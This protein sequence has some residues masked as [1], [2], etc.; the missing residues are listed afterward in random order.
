M[1]YASTIKNKA[2]RT[3]Y[4]TLVG[5]QRAITVT[6]CLAVP[7][8]V[9]YQV[10]LRYVFHSPLMGIEELLN[11]PIIWLYM[12]GGSVA[13]E[14]RNHISCGILTLYIKK[15]KSMKLYNVLRDVFSV[16]ICAWLTWWAKWYWSYS[17]GLWKTSDILRIPMFYAEGIILIGFVLMLFFGIVELVDDT[18]KYI[19][20]CK[21]TAEAKEEVTA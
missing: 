11:F 21:G 14:Q 3:I 1:D 16:V 17:F 12:L 9:V 13:S 6:V 5:I 8:I 19:E 2:W 15:D 4:K 7:L 20:A 18:K 10:L